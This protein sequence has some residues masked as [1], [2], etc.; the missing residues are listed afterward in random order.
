MLTRVAC[1]NLPLKFTLNSTQFI[2]RTST[3]I[4]FRLSPTS[5]NL[6]KKII[7]PISYV[8]LGWLKKVLKKIRK[9]I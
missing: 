6:K 5:L 1:A 7:A 4:I 8:V 9:S 2:C 3:D